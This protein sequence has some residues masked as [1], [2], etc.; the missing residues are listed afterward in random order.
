ML[1]SICRWLV[2]WVVQDMWSK[3]VHRSKIEMSVAEAT[4]KAA[5]V[6]ARGGGC[7]AVAAV[8]AVA[9]ITFGFG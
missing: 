2:E 3:L 6:T 9:L 4:T 5:E 8:A 7:Y 1:K